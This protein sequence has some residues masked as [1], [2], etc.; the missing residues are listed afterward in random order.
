[1][2]FFAALLFTL[3]FISGQTAAASPREDAEYIVE[4]VLSS[5]DPEQRTQFF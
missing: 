3:T 4:H 1:M 2:R 5:S